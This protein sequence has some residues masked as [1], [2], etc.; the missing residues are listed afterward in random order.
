MDPQVQN[1]RDT[2]SKEAPQVQI[3]DPQVQNPR[4]SSR[5]KLPKYKLWI[6]KYKNPRAIARR[7]PPKYKLWI[8]KSK[9]R[10]I[11]ETSRLGTDLQVLKLMLAGS[12]VTK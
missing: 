11:R 5:R 9:I 7:R 4:G 2:A 8:L 3:M 10:T 6:L 1:P 12:R